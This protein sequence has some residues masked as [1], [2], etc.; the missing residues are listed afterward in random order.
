MDISRSS[1]SSGK[2]LV[3]DTNMSILS[4]TATRPPV[5]STR[6]EQRETIELNQLSVSSGASGQEPVDQLPEHD[7]VSSRLRSKNKKT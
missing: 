7:P 1:A 3:T 5:R 6:Q 2:T 4:E